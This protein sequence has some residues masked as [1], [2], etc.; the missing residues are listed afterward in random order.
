MRTIVLRLHLAAG[1][2]T[3]GHLAQ[4]IPCNR[5]ELASLQS[6]CERTRAD[7]EKDEGENEP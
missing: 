4:A 1:L 5:R 3:H 2:S 7:L 6:L